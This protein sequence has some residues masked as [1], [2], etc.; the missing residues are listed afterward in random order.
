MI[1]TARSYS[2]FAITLF[3]ISSLSDLS[4]L[5]ESDSGSDERS[6]SAQAIE[7]NTIMLAKRKFVPTDV[8]RSSLS[9]KSLLQYSNHINYGP[10]IAYTAALLKRAAFNEYVKTHC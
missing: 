1:I 5:F 6:G 3:E 8:F 7:R 9:P 10:W 4:C 2:N